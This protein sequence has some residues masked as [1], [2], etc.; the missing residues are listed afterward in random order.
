MIHDPMVAAIRACGGATWSI[1][2]APDSPAVEGT[3]VYSERPTVIGEPDQVIR[4]IENMNRLLGID[5]FVSLVN[6]GGIEHELT[7]KSM[8]LFAKQVMPHFHSGGE[9][10]NPEIQNVLSAG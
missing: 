5:E 3:G 8:E 2:C 6:F 7:L 9:S 10:R 4:R 1:A